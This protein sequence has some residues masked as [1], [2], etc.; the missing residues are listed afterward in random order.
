[1]SKNVNDM[2]VK[3]LKAELAEYGVDPATAGAIEKQQLR[4]L[5]TKT[6]AQKRTIFFSLIALL[7]K[8]SFSFF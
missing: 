3:E 8:V 7:L 6:R 2:S 5:L 4:D 1:M